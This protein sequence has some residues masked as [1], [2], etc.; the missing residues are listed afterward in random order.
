MPRLRT[1]RPAANRPA[2]LRPTDHR[3][4]LRDFRLKPVHISRGQL[5]A[6]LDRGPDALCWKHDASDAAILDAARGIRGVDG[7]GTGLFPL[8]AGGESVKVYSIFR[9]DSGTDDYF[10][11]RTDYVF[12]VNTGLARALVS[13][14]PLRM[15]SHGHAAL[16]GSQAQRDRPPIRAVAH[17]PR[18]ERSAMRFG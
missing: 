12:V 3:A 2:A 7:I 4:W 18:P 15:P 13:R 5:I 16:A 1:R 9:T 14:R 6:F 8:G 10:F 17:G 11:V